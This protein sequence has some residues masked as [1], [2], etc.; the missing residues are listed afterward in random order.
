MK[1]DG[2]ILWEDTMGI[3]GNYWINDVLVDGARFVGVGG[4]ES[5]EKQGQNLYFYS[6]DF[7]GVPLSAYEEDV[8][9]DEDLAAITNYGGINKFYVGA[10]R[11]D[12][13]SYE[14]GV[15]L[16]IHTF[17]NNFAWIS[18]F[19]VS[20]IDPDIVGQMLPTS[21]G[22]ALVV[23]YTTGVVSGGNEIFV[24]KIGPSDNYPNTDLD[25]IV[26]NILTVEGTP[27]PNHVHIYP[28]PANDHLLIDFPAGAYKEV[29]VV[30]GA[31]NVLCAG[32]LSLGQ[33]LN[34]SDLPNGLYIVELSGEQ[35]LPVRQKFMVSH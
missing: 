11:D 29:R 32:S 6:V 5:P 20:H 35:G 16:L 23:G 1:E 30:D 14:G 22:G 17:L 2:K 24:L 3:N 7:S 15:D 21:D 27:M 4:T 33:S 31:G 9:G 18:G 19:G 8:A 34:V 28:N 25:M 13:G 12:D 10:E 26:D